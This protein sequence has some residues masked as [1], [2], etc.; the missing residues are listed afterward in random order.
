MPETDREKWDHKYQ[1]LASNSSDPSPLIVA[2]ANFLP[3]TGQALDIAGG[4]GNHAIWLSQRG[5]QVTLADISPVALEQ[6]T[7]Q[8]GQLGLT[9]QTCCIDFEQ[10]PFPLGPWDLILSNLYLY[11]PLF[12]AMQAALAPGGILVCAQP[13]RTN[14]SRHARPPERYLVDEGELPKL[15]NDLEIL[16]SWEGWSVT[17]RHESIVVARRP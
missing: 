7:Q 10:A 5:L 13:T 9:L 4:N 17:G 11:R 1:D 3:A 12:S 15:V 6:A 14:L 8:A 2:Q 16:H